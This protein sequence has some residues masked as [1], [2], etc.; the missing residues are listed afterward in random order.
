MWVFDPALVI[1]VGLGTHHERED[2]DNEDHVEE[3]EP[4]WSEGLY[5]VKEVAVG[6][7]LTEAPLDCHVKVLVLHQVLLLE[8][9]ELPLD[10]DEVSLK[11]RLAN[12]VR[13]VVFLVEVVI[14]QVDARDVCGLILVFLVLQ[15]WIKSVHRLS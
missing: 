3:A 9:L 7:V 4:V 2:Q 14:A 12:E 11:V 13:V 10:E 5:C 8:L 1:E 6:H 15:G